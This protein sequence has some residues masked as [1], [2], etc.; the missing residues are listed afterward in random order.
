V[1]RATRGRANPGL[2]NR[3]LRAALEARSRPAGQG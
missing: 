3:L 2:V 1:M